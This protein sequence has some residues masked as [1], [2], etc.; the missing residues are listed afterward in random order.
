MKTYNE[1]EAAKKLDSFSGWQFENDGIEKA[2]EFKDFTEAFSFM[3]K[4]AILSEKANHH[5]ELFN[6]Y[7]EVNVRFTTHDAG[8]LTDKDFDLARSIDK[9]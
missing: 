3:T 4:V 2:Y 5:P 7:N 1:E 9:Y 6:V 8:G